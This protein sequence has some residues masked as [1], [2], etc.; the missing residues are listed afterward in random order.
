LQ[1]PKIN[2]FTFEQAKVFMTHIGGYPGKYAPDVRPLLQK[3]PPDLFIC[4]HSHIVKVMRD[5]KLNLVHLNPGAAGKSGF[6]KV[7]TLILLEINEK[8]LQNI[9]IVELGKKGELTE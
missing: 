3:D 6:H 1:Y 9:Q 2:K 5:A 4:G 8:K 7:R